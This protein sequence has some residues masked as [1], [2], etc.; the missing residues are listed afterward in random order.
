[1]WAA[2]IMVRECKD[3]R[4]PEIH[5]NKKGGV[6]EAKDYLLFIPCF[7]GAWQD[8]HTCYIMKTFINHA[9]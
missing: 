8:A 3:L 6:S 1:M 5:T 7:P 2:L 4:A 9:L